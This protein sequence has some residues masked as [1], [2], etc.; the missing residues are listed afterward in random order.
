MVQPVL[1][2]AENLSL[3]S[4]GPEVA[5][6]YGYLSRFGYFRNEDLTKF[7]QWRPAVDA[8]AADEEHFDDNLDRAVRL[9]QAQNALIPD[10]VVGPK[11]LA[12]MGRPRCG[13]PDVVSGDGPRPFVTSG[14]RWDH[15]TVTYHFDSSGADLPAADAQAAVRAAFDRWAA[16]SPLR[17]QEVASGADIQIG[18]FTGDHGDGTSNAFD[19]VGGVLAHCFSPPPAGGSRAGDLH[20]DEAET[21]TT[22]NPPTG[23]DLLTVALHEIGHG[24]GLDHSSDPASVM[25]AFYGGIRRELTGDDIAGISAI[26]GGW[27]QPFPIAPPGHATPGAIT[28]V[29]RFPEHLDVFWIGPDGGVGTNYWHQNEGW[30]QP[31]P[32]APPGHA[33]PGAIT[34]VSRFPEHLDVFWIGPDG[35]VG[36]N[37]WSQP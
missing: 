18:W 5:K 26:Y 8:E 33:T 23:T 29:S 11:T 21:W 24:L 20:F 28:A 17:F 10:G 2:P 3:G 34:A 25:Y 32:I 9:F 37:Y 30:H 36:T 35:G 1:L 12:L 22:N 16:V 27:H 31:F 13:V 7:S 15:L 14:S 19:G 4:R 6:L